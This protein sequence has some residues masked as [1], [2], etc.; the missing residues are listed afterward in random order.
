MKNLHKIILIVF[1]FATITII[2]VVSLNTMQPG[3]FIFSENEN[4][5]LARFPRFNLANVLDTTFMQDF[6]DW[7][8]DRVLGRESWIRLKNG[9]E[10]LLGKLEIGGVYTA[11]DRILQI[12]NNYNEASVERNLAAM[13]VFAA[14]HSE[15]PVYL[16]LVPTAIE[17][18]RDSLPQ[19]APIGSQ[20]DF[21]RHCY[22]TLTEITSIDVLPLLSEHSN[23]YIYYRTDHHWT[24]TGAYIA[25][26]AAAVS[27]G[28][29]P[30]EPSRFNI[31]NVSNSFRGTLFSRTLD[32]SITPD[33]I[34]LYTL[35]EGNP[36]VAVTINDGSS[37]KT[38]N[39]LYFREYL[40]VK[41]KYSIFLGSPVPVVEI[42]SNL[43]GTG[44]RLLVIKDSYAHSFV[45]FLAKN[46]SEITMVDMRFI[47]ISYSELF[48]VDDYDAVLFLY[49]AD[50][51]SGDE[52]LV[53]L[54]RG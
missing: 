18:Y 41:D 12:W 15:V 19:S 22:D 44:R 9:T 38:Y 34:Q 17:I 42:I 10:R 27:M 21:I 26:T 7:A 25:Y 11:E 39:S 43:G 37:E 45:P 31:E 52:H 54:G 5:Y 16:M 24:S 4:R 28:F 1:F 33:I 8:S 51:F 29:T 49:N 47:N 20:K 30:L 2:P 6:D 3:E 14:R 23:S 53:K 46:F 36:E 35:A 48:N 13:N 32:N 40:D 50:T